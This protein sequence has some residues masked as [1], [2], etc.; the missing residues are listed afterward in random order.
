MPPDASI[1]GQKEDSPASG[2]ERGAQAPSA[3]EIG[4]TA[5]FAENSAPRPVKQKVDFFPNNDP[6]RNKILAKS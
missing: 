1:E 6:L 5:A 4:L 3:R 2:R